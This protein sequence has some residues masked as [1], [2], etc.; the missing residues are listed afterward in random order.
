M[1]SRRVQR[2][3]AYVTYTATRTV[4]GADERAAIGCLL[5][6]R[7]EST[8]VR[9]GVRVPRTF[10]DGQTVGTRHRAVRAAATCAQHIAI[11]SRAGRGLSVWWTL[12]FGARFMGR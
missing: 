6:S 10:K 1:D 3:D 4:D 12:I 5:R 2:F 8:G 11:G 9:L 7:P